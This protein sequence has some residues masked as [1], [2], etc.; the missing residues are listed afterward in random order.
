MPALFSHVTAPAASVCA[1]IT[2][3]VGTFLAPRLSRVAA[4]ERDS[5]LPLIAGTVLAP[6]TPDSRE[7]T[8]CRDLKGAF[9]SSAL[10]RLQMF[11]GITAPFA[12]F[13]WGNHAPSRVQFFG[14][15]L[16]RGRVP[17]RSSLLHKNILTHVEAVCPICAAPEGT[18]DHIFAG[19]AFARGFWGV[20]WG[21]PA[22][23]ADVSLFYTL[24]RD[25][26]PRLSPCFVSSSFGST[27][28]G[29]FSVP[30]TRAWPS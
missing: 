15:L 21:G 27:G 30:R 20:V 5:L 16:A 24:C 10:Y 8:K 18:A 12:A 2:T 4:R 25:R 1:V 29:W 19:C 11:G 6:G 7:L 26:L 23:D 28:M 9:S 3:G 22:P 13:V 14:W 17:S